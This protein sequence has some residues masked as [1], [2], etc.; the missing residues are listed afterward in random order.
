MKETKNINTKEIIEQSKIKSYKNDVKKTPYMDYVFNVSPKSSHF[1]NLFWAY[2]VGGLICSLG[3]IIIDLLV[4]NGIEDKVASVFASC[5]LVALAA[6][7][8][9]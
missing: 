4:Q 9:G 5:I 3:Q 6:C 7:A 1:K 2:F 8:T